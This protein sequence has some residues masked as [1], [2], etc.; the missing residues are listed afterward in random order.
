MLGGGALKTPST[1]NEKQ[2]LQMTLGTNPQSGMKAQKRTNIE[3][4]IKLIH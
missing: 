3:K 2:E 4:A 1:K